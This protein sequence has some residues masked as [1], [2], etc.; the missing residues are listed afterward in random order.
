MDSRVKILDDGRIYMYIPSECVEIMRGYQY[1]LVC[2]PDD[3]PIGIEEYEKYSLI[4]LEDED[5]FVCLG[6]MTD[7]HIERLGMFPTLE[8]VKAYID[9]HKSAPWGV[10]AIARKNRWRR[11]SEKGVSLTLQD[12][13]GR[14]LKY[15]RREG[16]AEIE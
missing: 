1:D 5:V 4:E 12:E 13:N 2:F 8:S 16:R 7:L 6:S 3:K 15:Y 11:V 14:T 9:A 10:S